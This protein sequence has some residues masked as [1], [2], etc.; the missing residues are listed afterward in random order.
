[1]SN[2]NVALVFP[3]AGSETVQ[4]FEYPA[5]RLKNFV[6][7]LMERI[8]FKTPKIGA[9]FLMVSFR[10]FYPVVY[11]GRRYPPITHKLPRLR[12]SVYLLGSKDEN[13]ALVKV[14]L[15]W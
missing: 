15:L 11:G 10:S 3:L 8:L 1:M 5:P 6:S 4:F 14:P 12:C 7:H 2:L 9:F 13:P